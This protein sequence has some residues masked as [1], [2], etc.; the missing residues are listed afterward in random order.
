MTVKKRLF[1][2]NILMIV[3]PV[4]MTMIVGLCCVGAVWFTIQHGGG[5]G[6]E[7][8]GEF[9]WVSQA[10]VELAERALDADKDH[11]DEKF[12]VLENLLRANAI[13]LVVK[14]EA[15]IIY[16]HGDTFPED[17]NLLQAAE[18]MGVDG[19]LVSAG[20]R[21]I[22][23]THLNTGGQSY[24][25]AV[26]GSQ[27][28]I[29]NRSIHLVTVLVCILL[30]FT[31]FISIFVT[32]RF[33]T[34]FVFRKI[35]EP[36]DIL[37]NGVKE[38]GD[39]NLDCR[40]SYTGKDEFA[41]VC[42]AFN[43]M[44]D[45]LKTSVERSRKDEE[46]RKELLAGISH[47]L[48]SPLTS[49]RAYVEGLLDGVASTP[50][51]QRQYLT[52]IRNKAE[53]IDRLVS[54]LFLFSKLDLD[55]YP[56]ELR[57][58]RLDEMA[59]MLVR[60]TEGEYLQKGLD[61]SVATDPVTV[62]ADP[63]QL[64]RVLTNIMD[65]SAKYKIADIGYLQITVEN[66]GKEGRVTLSDDGPGVSEDA[67]PKLFDVFYRSDPARKNPAG[68]SG[69]GLAIAAKTIQKM[70]GTIQ[71]ANRPEGGLSITITLPEEEADY[72][73]HSDH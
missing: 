30:L 52:T 33:L 68:G 60:E 62:L 53:D 59:V 9:Y 7:D 12:A 72:E 63:E 8:S 24:Q 23:V 10:A 43:E 39:G 67:L 15:G 1:L 61:V 47:D 13:R 19:T 42:T 44:A 49:I 34:K 64:R 40:I 3:V 16:S 20:T 28:E 29:S 41:P 5:L 58:I 66:S 6:L 2:S 54:Q 73:N 17:P 31:I 50:Q 48:R 36:L 18:Q 11:Q 38:I 35:E 25:V 55:E 70:G 45:R 37:A 57:P 26:F 32:N 22:F 27:A 65:N 56:M 14:G 46:S 21:S 69:L 71:A 4:V 51:A